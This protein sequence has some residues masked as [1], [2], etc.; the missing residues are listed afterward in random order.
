[1]HSGLK[2]GWAVF[3]PGYLV[4]S[5]LKPNVQEHFSRD[6]ENWQ[7]G[8]L[9]EIN[10]ALCMIW[11]D[12]IFV[13][14]FYAIAFLGLK[15]VRQKVHKSE[16]TIVSRQNSI[17]QYWGVKFRWREDLKNY[18]LL[19]LKWLTTWKQEMLA[20]LKYIY[21]LWAP[22]SRLRPFRPALGPL[23]LLDNVLHAHRALRTCDP[24]NGALIG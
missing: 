24:R 16:T 17:N 11:P 13:I 23:G 6:G 3:P 14:F 4:V 12:L 2:V 18:E 15:I 22:T 19:T 10:I 20:H 21:T 5:H 8:S 1:M 7:E 9:L